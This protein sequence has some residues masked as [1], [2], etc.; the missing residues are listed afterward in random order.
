MESTAKYLSSRYEQIVSA[1]SHCDELA[2]KEMVE[3]G[4]ASTSVQSAGAAGGGHEARVAGRVN[5]AQCD[6]CKACSVHLTTS[7]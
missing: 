3:P 6:S 7:Y 2:H 5:A 4:L 1:A